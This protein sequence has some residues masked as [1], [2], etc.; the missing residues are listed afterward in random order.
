[1]NRSICL[2]LI[3]PALIC[4]VA[5]SPVAHADAPTARKDCDELRG[6]IAAKI[7]AKGVPHYLL[8]VVEPGQEGETRIVGSCN[9]GS[10]RI[11][12][13]RLAGPPQQAVVTVAGGSSGFS[14]ESMAQHEM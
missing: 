1:M 10:A 5:A 13:E 2:A 4:L 9:G 11:A 3:C 14:S 12:Y 8:Q 6:E 7:D